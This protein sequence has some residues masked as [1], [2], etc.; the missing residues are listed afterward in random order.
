M[1]N[2]SRQSLIDDDDRPKEGLNKEQECLLIGQDRPMEAPEINS[3]NKE[4][5]NLFNGEVLYLEGTRSKVPDQMIESSFKEEDRWLNNLVYPALMR[6]LDPKKMV[7]GGLN[8]YFKREKFLF[9]REDRDEKLI[10]RIFC[11]KRKINKK[12]A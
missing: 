2:E 5:D 12:F 4:I 3:L 1:R 9:E 8:P 11:K 7:L 10:K 6:S